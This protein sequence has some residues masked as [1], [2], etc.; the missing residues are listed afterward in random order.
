MRLRF[1]TA[2]AIFCIFAT[3]GFAQ[4]NASGP[5]QRILL[6]QILTQ[7]YQPSEVGKRLMGVGAD[8]DV[9][10]PG[11]IMVVQREGLYG[12]LIRNETASLAIHGREATLFRG[13]QDYAVPVGERYYV[14]AIHVGPSTVDVGLLSARKVSTSH[15]MGRV[16]TTTSFYFPEELLANAEKDPVVREIDQWL[17]PEGRG[18]VSSA[19]PVVAPAPVP[20]PAPTATPVTAP[21]ASTPAAAMAS[22]PDTLNPGMT[23]EQVLAVLGK[24]QREITF[25]AQ[26]W[27]HYPGMV[28]LLN[29]GKLAS[30]EQVGPASTAS[31]ALHSDPSGAEIYIDGQLAGSTP[32]TLQLPS[33][34][35]QIGVRLAGYQDWVRDVKVLAGSETQ[36]EAKLEKK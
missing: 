20:A 30:V 14:T 24:P 21:A 36:F 22:A 11:I 6:E 8:T 29:D 31:V 26:S 17:L 13:H 19:P 18:G 9:R 10:K 23:R 5:N 7:I 34:T 3:I 32:S 27:L 25:Q 16:W 4:E 35:H 33:G 2:V 1:A 28:V 12:S 15:G